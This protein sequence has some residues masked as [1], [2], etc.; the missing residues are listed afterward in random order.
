MQEIIGA[1][2]F[3][4]FRHENFGGAVSEGSRKSAT[5][6]GKGTATKQMNFCHLGKMN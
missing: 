3:R 2:P 6:V 4:T 5:F 1:S